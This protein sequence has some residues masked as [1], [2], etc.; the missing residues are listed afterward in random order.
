MRGKFWKMGWKL[1]EKGDKFRDFCANPEN[2]NQK[3]GKSRANSGTCLDFV[4]VAARDEERL[5]LVEADPA[6]RPVVLVELVQ[7]GAHTAIGIFFKILGSI[8]TQNLD[9]FE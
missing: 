2:W 9:Q 1:H 8:Y 6:H 5:L 3:T 7:Q 4:V